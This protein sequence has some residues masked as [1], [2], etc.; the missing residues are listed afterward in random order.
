MCQETLSQ[1]TYA[2]RAV[3]PRHV[4]MGLTSFIW[5]SA[6]SE[7]EWYSPN[8][9]N[10]L[11]EPLEKAAWPMGTSALKAGGRAVPLLGHAVNT[12]L[13]AVSAGASDE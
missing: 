12:A 3:A 10:R 4:T 11:A 9:P 13:L 6:G 8:P 2:C 1:N 5:P 7:T